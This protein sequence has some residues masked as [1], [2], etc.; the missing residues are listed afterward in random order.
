MTDYR[1]RRLRAAQGLPPLA[2]RAIPEKTWTPDQTPGQLFQPWALTL[3]LDAG[4]HYDPELSEALG[5]SVGDVDRWEEGI[6]IPT[7]EQ[8]GRIAD[9][10]SYPLRWFYRVGPPP[11]M[12]HVFMCPG[13]PVELD[14]IIPIGRGRWK[15]KRDRPDALLPPQLPLG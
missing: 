7:V 2:R 9:V 8:A 4:G 13:G 3:A 15:I 5:C 6:E 12:E 11:I 14:E 1:S 10:T